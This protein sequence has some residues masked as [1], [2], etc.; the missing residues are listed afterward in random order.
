MQFIRRPD[1]A[2][3]FTRNQWI[4]GCIAAFVGCGMTARD[5]SAPGQ[6]LHLPE[7]LK[8]SQIPSDFWIF[9]QISQDGLLQLVD[10]CFVSLL[11]L[12]LAPHH[13]PPEVRHPLTG[14]EDT[15]LPRLHK[16]YSHGILSSSHSSHMKGLKGQT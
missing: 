10:L 1:P 9:F 14:R 13:Q 11:E 4:S 6:T 15:N 12:S 3:K 8:E 16:S 2:S 5:C 7:G